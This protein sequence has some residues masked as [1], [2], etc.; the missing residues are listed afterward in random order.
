VP[1]EVSAPLPPELRRYLERL[2][3]AL[4]ADPS[5]IDAALRTYL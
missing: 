1:V 2:A 4:E 3:A 5:G